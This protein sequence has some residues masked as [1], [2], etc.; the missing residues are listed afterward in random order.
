LQIGKKS[1]ANYANLRSLSSTILTLLLSTVNTS[2]LSTS[3]PK[4][5][6]EKRKYW[7]HYIETPIVSLNFYPDTHRLPGKKSKQL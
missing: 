4:I 1:T 2:T 7:K 3:T 5:V 6:S